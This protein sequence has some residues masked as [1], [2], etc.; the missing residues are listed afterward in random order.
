MDKSDDLLID[1]QHPETADSILLYTYKVP[2]FVIDSYTK[3]VMH[4]FGF[5]EK[6][7]DELKNLFESN[8]KK[9][10][11]IYQ[12]FHALLVEHAKRKV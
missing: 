10:Y 3:R 2:S 11:K 5:S 9:D 1:L 4:K 6:T 8:L 12:E 7:Y